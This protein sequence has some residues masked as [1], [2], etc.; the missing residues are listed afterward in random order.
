[1]KERSADPTV[2]SLLSQIEKQLSVIHGASVKLDGNAP[3][4]ERAYEKVGS[5]GLLLNL[6]CMSRWAGFSRAVE[7][8]ASNDEATA[9]GMAKYIEGARHTAIRRMKARLALQRAD[10]L[11]H[12]GKPEEAKPVYVVALRTDEPGIR[13]S[14]W[15]GLGCARRT[16]HRLESALDAF[17][18]AIRIEPSA[19]TYANAGS[20]C[21]D[22][23][24]FQEATDAYRGALRPFPPDDPGLRSNTL[25]ATIGR[26]DMTPEEVFEAHRSWGAR[27]VE[28]QAPYRKTVQRDPD[29]KRKLRIGYVSPDLCL[30][31]VSFFISPILAAHDKSNFEIVCYFNGE[32]FDAVSSM[33]QARSDKWRNIFGAPDDAVAQM[34]EA[35]GIDIL[36]DLAGHTVHHRTV[37]F[38]RK[39]APVQATYLGYACTTGLSTMDYRITDAYADP[40]GMTEHLHTEELVRLPSSFLAYEPPAGTPDVAPPPCLKNGFI[41][42]GSFNAPRKLTKQVIKTWCRILL[43]VPNSRLVLKSRAFD[44]DACWERLLDE[45]RLRGVES[46]R[47]VRLPYKPMMKDHLEQYAEIDIALDPWPY[48]GTTTTLEA[49]WMGVPVVSLRGKAH[50]GLVGASI[51]RNVGFHET[52]ARDEKEYVDACIVLANQERLHHLRRMM[53]IHLQNSPI[54]DATGFTRGL[55]DAY[56]TMWRKWCAEHPTGVES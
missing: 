43:S 51:L 32:K 28:L 14:A 29:P 23:R 45:T 7:A 30:H 55:E 5:I 27:L 49:L 38:A 40:P 24:L 19:L 15:N 16:T 4:D 50:A 2:L 53:R 34:I 35:D 37:L 33:L 20:T 25:F 18:Q 44:E 56:R 21:D 42:F 3:M 39:T 54:M 13:A 41:S 9:T 8:R 1:M 11:L 46:W 31:P 52:V 17:K 22:L 47:V 10:K 26:E 36:V 12:T 6:F 48:N